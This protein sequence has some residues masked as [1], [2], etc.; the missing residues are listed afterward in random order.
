MS[1]TS[2]TKTG[3]S[4]SRLTRGQGNFIAYASPVTQS[5]LT[6]L[7]NAK[8]RATFHPVTTYINADVAVLTH[9]QTADND[10]HIIGV[11]LKPTLDVAKMSDADI[12]ATL[13]DHSNSIF[14]VIN[15]H[16]KFLRV[17]VDQMSDRL[18]SLANSM[19]FVTTSYNIDTA[20]TFIL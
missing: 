12:L 8:V 17:G 7:R 9:I 4:H 5:I 13:Q 16:P 14:G 19:G 2:A 11:R 15:K 20:G 6:T 3:K 18:A 10:G 1:K